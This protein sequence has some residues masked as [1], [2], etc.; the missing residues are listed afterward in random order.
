VQRGYNLVHWTRDGMTYW[1]ASDLETAELMH[2]EALLA[3][4]SSM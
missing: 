2:L 3:S 1:L 4:S